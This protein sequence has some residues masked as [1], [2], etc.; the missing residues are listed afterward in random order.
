MTIWTKVN[1]RNIFENILRDKEYIGTYKDQKTYS[2][3]DS[4]FVR[5]ILES[6]INESTEIAL[7]C[8]AQGSVSIRNEKDILV[9]VNSD[10]MII[11][12]GVLA[13]RELV[14]VATMSLLL[15]KIEYANANNFC[16]PACTF[17]SFGWSKSTKKIIEQKQ[18][19]LL[20]KK[21]MRS[22]MG[23]KPKDA[24]PYEEKK[25]ARA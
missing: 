25:N 18:M 4:G 1:L 12:H 17:I 5:E 20:N 13:W 24:I 6:K 19:K 10:G 16:S 21:K 15:Y 7:F 2:Y 22:S 23:D 3:F 11:T 14:G 8:S 9:V